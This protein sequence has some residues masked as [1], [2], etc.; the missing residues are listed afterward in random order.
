MFVDLGKIMRGG[1]ISAV[2]VICIN[3]RYRVLY[4]TS[5]PL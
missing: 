5:Y 1:V 3:N 2:T 4:F